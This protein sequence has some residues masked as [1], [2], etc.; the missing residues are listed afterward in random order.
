[1]LVQVL[2]HIPSVSLS[3][4]LSVCLSVG[5]SIWPVDCC[6]TAEW[7]CMVFGIM[8]RLGPRMGQIVEIG[9]CPARMGLWGGYMAPHCNQWEFV[10]RFCESA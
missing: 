3:V 2:S 9:D 8:G 10:A 5:R 6:K 7:I 1:V 4:C